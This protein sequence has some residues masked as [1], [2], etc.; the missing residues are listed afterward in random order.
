MQR[1][2]FSQLAR[3]ALGAA[4]VVLIG[5]SAP[6]SGVDLADLDPTC[7]ACDDFYQYATGG[8]MKNHPLPPAYS[9]LGSFGVLADQNQDVLH[10]ILDQSAAAHPAAGS[11]EQKIGDYYA[12]CMDVAA[13]DAAGLA[14]LAPLFTAVAKVTDVRSLAGP[15]AELASEGVSGPFSFGAG[16]DDHNATMTIAQLRQ[17]GIGMPDRDAYLGDDARSQAIRSAYVTHVAQM[18]GLLGD[19]PDVAAKNAQTVLA[20]ETYLARNQLSRVAQR[21]PAATDHRMTLAQL[22]ALAPNFD[23]AEY[24]RALGVA[25]DAP[26]NVAQPTFFKALSDGLATANAADLRTYLRWHVVHA[27]ANSLGKAFVDSDFAFFSKTLRGTQEQQPRWKQCVSATNG[28]LSDALGQAYV[29]KTF[30]PAAKARALAMVQNVKLTLRDDIATL[31]WM[32]AQTRE[33][34]VAKLDA[35]GLKIGYPDKWR[36]YSR[37][38][39]GRASYPSNALAVNRFRFADTLV[40]VGKPVDR[41]RWGMTPPTVNASYSPNNNDIT[42]PAGILQ[43]PFYD[44]DADMAVNYGGIGAVIGHE[45][46]HGFDD[47][48]RKY[49]LNGNL[50]DWWAPQD[51]A[52]FTARANCVIKQYDALS[53][54]PGV[55]ENGKLVEGEAIAD[56]GGITIAYKAFEKWQA[57]NP[58]RTLDGFSPEQRFFLGFARIWAENQTPQNIALQAK[59]DVH[60]FGKLRVNATVSNM[61]EFMA[62]WQCP[63][64]VAMVRPPADRCRIW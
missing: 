60:A 1:F 47:E 37:L 3:V 10:G 25:A 31:D 24:F 49:D 48:G 35:F 58:R 50:T 18:F 14:P 29:E 42:F 22:A 43:P 13:I 46:T 57:Q 15:L 36:D 34:A 33:R 17:G 52:D 63:L 40:R 2:T 11:N 54:A 51:A 61:P 27:Y 26:L 16:A 56:L 7:K 20:L 12:A 6:K 23:W 19:P 28:A 32:T 30:P 55:A 45:S 4:F 44:K 8:W 59:T 39:I 64:G 62:A 53:P 38:P 9:R 41:A 21:D 5:A